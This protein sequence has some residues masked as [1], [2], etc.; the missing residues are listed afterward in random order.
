MYGYFSAEE[1]YDDTY[2][3]DLTT[4]NYTAGPKLLT[5]RLRHTC[6]YISATNEIIV[7]GGQINKLNATCENLTHKTVEIIDLD[8]NTIRYGK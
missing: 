3:L 5:A 8:T 7:A 2:F 4:L 6:H 1:T